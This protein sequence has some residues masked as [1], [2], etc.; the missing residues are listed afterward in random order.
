MKKKI[1]LT[2]LLLLPLHVFAD[3]RVQIP[4]DETGNF[5]GGWLSLP[6][7]YSDW[8]NV[9]EPTNCSNW[10]PSTDTVTLNET[11]VQTASGCT[12]NQSRT[13]TQKEKNA[14][15]AEERTVSTKTETRTITDGTAKRA[16]KGTKQSNCRIDLSGIN[17]TFVRV[18]NGTDYLFYYNYK[19]IGKTWSTTGTSVLPYNGYYYYPGKLVSGEPRNGYYE[20]CRQ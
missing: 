2:T 13:V 8:S 12:Q 6:L 20:I 14:K 7:I 4:F 9:G 19:E 17:P 10:T 16:A 18:S 5:K 3:F 11:F 1:L 15:T